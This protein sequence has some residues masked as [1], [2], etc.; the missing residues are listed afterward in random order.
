M[1]Y[2]YY[3]SYQPRFNASSITSPNMLTE[4]SGYNRKWS[5]QNTLVFNKVF[6]EDHSFK[7]L[8]GTEYISSYGRSLSASRVDFFSDDPNYSYL[9][10]GG[11]VGQNNGSQ[12]FNSALYSIFSRL[13]YAYK[14]K[15]LLMGTLERQWS[16]VFV[17][18]TGIVFSLL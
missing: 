5:W 9:S 17:R 10:N 13:D 11:V 14:D 12:A 16:S 7:L 6:H 4:G 2:Q 3:Y 15:Y 18:K 8:I 1:D